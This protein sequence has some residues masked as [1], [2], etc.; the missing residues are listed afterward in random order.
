MEESRPSNGSK[1]SKELTSH[2]MDALL[3]GH[4]DRSAWALDSALY[5]S[6]ELA[7]ALWQRGLACF[8]SGRYED[9]MS[10]LEADM[11]ENG[12]D[13]EEVLWHFFCCCKLRGFK[14]AQEEGLLPLRG[15]PQVPPMVEVLK[16]CQGNGTIEEV[17]AAASNPDGS[18]VPSYNGCSALAYAHFYVGLYHE[19]Q[20]D[21]DMAENHL[22]K[23]AEMKSPDYIGRLMELHYRLFSETT[24]KRRQVPSFYLGDKPNGY[25][26]SSIIQ[27]G[28]QLSE[29]HLVNSGPRSLAE[30]VAVL[31]QCYD[32]G[33]R[34]FDCGDIY[35]GVEDLYGKL[36]LAH[37]SRGGRMEDI[38]LHTKL[39]PDLDAARAG[40]VGSS[41]VKSVVLRSLNR[42]GVRC[43]NL[44]Q[45]HWW[46]YSIPGYVEAA[47]VLMHL[48]REG[49]VR[50]IGLTNFDLQHTKELVDA[51]IPIASTQVSLCSTSYSY[52][53]IGIVAHM[54]MYKYVPN[55]SMNF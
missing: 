28:W 35:S 43:V 31:L 25:L 50:Q 1:L 37:L 4:F 16:L 51:G 34:T 38:V 6:P 11:E 15:T 12:S 24:L 49:V 33:I 39:V 8:Y 54:H 10:Q 40:K 53:A 2:G 19:M 41:Y 17:F 55:P 3:Q 7:P 9:G 29:G 5:L 22:R 32:A 18:P 21:I 48:Q 44:V 20:G 27:G 13:V 23:A 30:S 46:D 42:L 14:K 52:S 47:R 45:L 26:C 36:V